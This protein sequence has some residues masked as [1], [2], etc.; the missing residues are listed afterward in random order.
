MIPPPQP[1]KVLPATSRLGQHDAPP[2]SWLPACILTAAL[3]A[4]LYQ[5]WA[6]FLNPDEALHNL[7]ASQNSVR[8]AYHAA[9]TQ[10]H[11]PL[12]I[13]VLYYWRSL[14]HSE[15]ML[16]LPSVL[17]GTA[18][19]WFA[20]QW[21]KL[22]TDRSTAFLGLLLFA[23]APSL[24]GLSAEVRQYALLLFF[25]SA[26]LYLSERALQHNSA[27][28]MI[29]FSLS[30]YGA[31]LSHYSSLI[32]AFTLGI[33]LLVRLYPYGVRLRLFAVWGIGQI[34][35]LALVA[36]FLLTHVAHLREVGMAQGISETWLRKSFFHPAQNHAL[37]FIAAQ[38]LRVFTFLLSH[39]VAGTLALIAFLIG[40]VSLFR[41][42]TS[43]AENRPSPR[44]LA[45]LLVLPF[46]V[47][48][49]AALAGA[50]PY[51]ATRH[52]S[53]LALFGLSGA[54]IGLTT[55]KPARWWST[56]LIV[57]ACL[58]FCN[59]F[60]A[61]APLIKAKNH[62]RILMERAID[63]LHASAA[64]GST[65]FAD[66]ESALV[67]GYYACGHGV[68]QIFPPYQS[69]V[70]NDCGPYK[71]FSARPEEWKFTAEDFS[72]QYGRFAQS[73]PG[74][75]GPVEA[76]PVDAEKKLWMFNTGWIADSD[77][78]ALEKFL[79]QDGCSPQHFGENIFICQFAVREAAPPSNPN[80]H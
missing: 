43:S 52:N 68:V 24:V 64:P 56:P 7:L 22:V 72:D 8:M 2:H 61:P 66:Y 41:K 42:K 47:N 51:G 10:A 67:L 4:R 65:F 11:P 27:P 17:A 21:L 62:R 16:R 20:Y 1:S 70:P 12:L 75:V 32:F 23:F 48:C 59:F 6:Y 38:T 34:A 29:L 44:Q 36:Y 63:A 69:F 28:C 45:L 71:I 46:A 76:G 31:L 54:C 35:A 78:R 49:A 40:I 30:L 77:T 80:P 33:Y 26:C 60:P 13:L 58:A 79:R 55:W 57:A 37:I 39:G 5:A 25:A 19:C 14:G 15:L 18:A 9:L 74:V 3:I 50:Y 73:Y 53:L